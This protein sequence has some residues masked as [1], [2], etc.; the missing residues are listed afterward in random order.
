MNRLQ[1][2]QNIINL[3]YR[4]E[5]VQRQQLGKQINHMNLL[6]DVIEH[7]RIE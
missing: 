2:N 5:D 6:Y 3:S 1:E 7:D 4:Y